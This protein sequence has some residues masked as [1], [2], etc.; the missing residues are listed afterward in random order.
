VRV[1]SSQPIWVTQRIIGWGG[2]KE[3]FGNPTTLAATDW[4]LTWYDMQGAESDAIH[5]INT[6][7]SD[8][9]VQVYVGGELQSTLTVSAGEAMFVYYL[10]LIAGPV[11]VV[12]DVPIMMSQ[13]ILGWQS[14]EETIG[15]SIAV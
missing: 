5:I 7:T 13:R 3:V 2:W 4:Y 11:R 1:V 12:S 9:T 6:G 10:G 14:F 15:A 8:A